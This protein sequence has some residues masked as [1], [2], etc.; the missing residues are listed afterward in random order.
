[1]AIKFVQADIPKVLNKILLSDA[2]NGPEKI[3]A[4]NLLYNLTLFNNVH[5]KLIEEKILDSIVKKLGEFIEK[6]HSDSTNNDFS[7]I[8]LIFKILINFCGNSVIIEDLLKSKI[9]EKMNSIFQKFNELSFLSHLYI[10]SLKQISSSY[11]GVM[12]L[13]NS[14]LKLIEIC[15]F[16]LES[17]NAV[18]IEDTKFIVDKVLDEEMMRQ[19]VG[20]I[21]KGEELANQLIILSCLSLENRALDSLRN[22]ALINKAISLMDND[23]VTTRHKISVIASI[24]LMVSLDETNAKHFESISGVDAILGKISTEDNLFVWYLITELMITSLGKLTVEEMQAQLNKKYFLNVIQKFEKMNPIFDSF[25][26]NALTVE[27]SINSINYNQ[28]EIAKFVLKTL[29]NIK[30]ADIVDPKL[31][32][33]FLTCKLY[34]R[35]IFW[36][37]TLLKTK[38]NVTDYEF[39]EPM[40]NNIFLMMKLFKNSKSL[41]VKIFEMFSVYPLNDVVVNFLSNNQWQQFLFDI[42][43]KKPNW[44]KFSLFVLR[45]FDSIVKNKNNIKVL[46]SNPSTVKLI[47]TIKNF[48]IEEDYREFEEEESDD[49][50]LN[51]M[52]KEQQVE[53][54][55]YSE[56]KEIQ[57]KA[58]ALIEQLI[59]SSSLVTFKGNIERGIA[60]FKPKPE[61]IQILRADYAILACINSINYFGIEG[62]KNNL[63]NVLNGYIEALEKV[64]H[65]E[66]FNEKEKLIAD[67]IRSIAN[68]ICITWSE[69]GSKQYEVSD[70]SVIVFSLFIK[71]LKNSIGPLQ[72]YVILKAF[73][74]W[75]LNR[76]EII[77]SYTGEHKNYVYFHDHF[78]LISSNKL[79]STLV[80]TLDCL[81]ENHQ[82]FNKNQKIIILNLEIINLLCQISRT[83]KLKVSGSFIPQILEI[84][85]ADNFD[86]EC[87]KKSI[88][89]L[90]MFTGTDNQTEEIN[91]QAIK[92][93]LNANGLAKIFKSISISGFDVEYINLCKPLIEGLI[94]KDSESDSSM[95]KDFVDQF[96]QKVDKFNEMTDDQKKD[97]KN[98]K[99]LSTV[100]SQLNNFCLVE[101][102][103]YYMIESKCTNKFNAVWDYTNT[104]KVADLSQA[105]VLGEIEKLSAQ[106]ILNSITSN[107]PTSNILKD[108]KENVGDYP[109]KADILTNCFK[110]LLNGYR[111]PE[112]VA[113]C[114]KI[115]NSCFPS[116]FSGECLDV[117]KKLNAAETVDTI[118]KMY[119]NDTDKELAKGT[120]EMYLNLTNS[121]KDDGSNSLVQ[122]VIKD[123]DN[124]LLHESP[125]DL[126]KNIKSL[127]PLLDKAAVLTKEDKAALEK[128]VLNSLKFLKK[129]FEDKLQKDCLQV[130]NNSLSN[131]T[132]PNLTTNERS[133]LAPEINLSQHLAFLIQNLPQSSIDSLSQDKDIIKLMEVP[134][135]LNGEMNSLKLLNDFLNNKDFLGKSKNGGMFEIATYLLLRKNKDAF[136]VASYNENEGFDKSVLFSLKNSNIQ[137]LGASVLLDKPKD[138]VNIFAST[139]M[140]EKP[141]QSR[142]FKKSKIED[143]KENFSLYTDVINKIVNPEKFNSIID[144]YLERVKAY[145]NASVPSIFSLV[146]SSRYLVS[147]L[148]I[149][150]S[151]YDFKPYA[152][153]F[154]NAFLDYFKK[155]S[156]SALPNKKL[157][158]LTEEIFARCAKKY[159][160]TKE[161]LRNTKLWNRMI[162][163]YFSLKPELVLGNPNKI[164]KNLSLAK[165]QLS[166]KN[167]I[168]VSFGKSSGKI[169]FMVDFSLINI[170]SGK[171]QN[172]LLPILANIK[173]IINKGKMTPV[174]FFN[175]LEGISR[176]QLASSEIM[177][178]DLFE[179]YITL[180]NNFEDYD[181]KKAFVEMSNIMINCL[182]N[183]DDLEF[184]K[185][186]LNQ[187]VHSDNFSKKFFDVIEKFQKS[188]FK[189]NTLALVHIFR[190]IKNPSSFYDQN[191]PEKILEVIGGGEEWKPDM[192]MYFMLFALMT[193]NDSFENM[194]SGLGYFAQIKQ[195]FQDDAINKDYKYEPLEKLGNDSVSFS[196][197]QEI[198]VQEIMIFTICDYLKYPHNTIGQKSMVNKVY[199]FELLKGFKKFTKD[200]I[201]AVKTIEAIRLI[202]QNFTEENF[203]QN[204]PELAAMKNDLNV[205]LTKHTTNK[206]VVKEIQEILNI[207]DRLQSQAAEREKQKEVKVKEDE[208]LTQ[209]AEDKPE[210]ARRMSKEDYMKLFTQK[211][212]KNEMNQFNISIT[213]LLGMLKEIN[214]RL[215]T[216]PLDDFHKNLMSIC[217][218]KING[219]FAEHSNLSVYNLYSLEVPINLR[220]I[221]NNQNAEVFYRVQCIK[222]LIDFANIED[223]LLKMLLTDFYMNK[224]IE[225]NNSILT[226]DKKL[227]SLTADEK[228]ILDNDL[229]HLKQLTRTAK[230]VGLFNDN[231]TDSG[232]LIGNMSR[233]LKSHIQLLPIKIFVIE[234]FNNLMENSKMPK[235]EEEFLNNQKLLFDE[236]Y[237]EK[238][239]VLP[240]LTSFALVAKSSKE[241]KIKLVNDGMVNHLKTFAEIYPK[242][243]FGNRN[244][245]A[246]ILELVNECPENHDPILRSSILPYLASAFNNAIGNK[247]LYE[248]VSKIILQIGY[249]NNDKKMRLIQI[250][251]SAGLITLFDIFSTG[252][253]ADPEICSSILKCMA[254]FSVMPVGAEHLLKDKIILSFQQYFNSHKESSPEQVK[255]VMITMSNMAFMPNKQNF[256]MILNDGGIQLILD[257]FVFAESQNDTD[258][259]E[260]CTDALIQMSLE[261]KALSFLELTNSLDLVMSVLR[262]QANDRLIYKG[263]MCLNQYSRKD[264]FAN[265]ILEK[266]GHS[267]AAEIVKSNPKDYKNFLQSVKLLKSLINHNKGKLTRFSQCGV[268]DKIIQSFSEDLP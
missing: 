242:N 42:V 218:D 90:K 153:K 264:S 146:V 265:K 224:C 219:H 201:L 168:K 3:Q 215:E 222:F 246:V 75:L 125:Q 170:L 145:D 51:S 120:R 92:N 197:S 239:V 184:L 28:G 256:D 251:F 88:E 1:V 108:W 198:R 58:L 91:H 165:P 203:T 20:K 252:E 49:V 45:F 48:I 143:L 109:N 21:T 63:H 259:I 174:Q 128:R 64:T 83:W 52:K 213:D 56:E 25:L 44:K 228:S 89:L 122:K 227:D 195:Y 5:K 60:N 236:N 244:L 107:N 111:N 214:K 193:E 162:K 144:E 61:I 117:Y 12:F 209:L 266:G 85:N 23:K 263:L 240:L 149:K 194:L 148:H 72:S 94:F 142:I 163:F 132:I 116:E 11:D 78:M 136:K 196:P 225:N 65:N 71:Y 59:D 243:E 22:P 150:D 248:N 39:T 206:V 95:T 154:K 235:I 35:N 79:D 97:P 10:N 37:I 208:K 230:G 84:L 205:E 123:I 24:T 46:Q 255:L 210:F 50:Q 32:L 98:L 267:I 156:K 254:N 124:S 190:R 43:L 257:C 119:E 250:G 177:K 238:T 47:A 217:I 16:A 189:Q 57:R 185:N 103:Q 171:N 245:S 36:M 134:L 169:D 192:E 113:T 223:I 186:N 31:A 216:K 234:I 253:T 87:D 226:P 141:D 204:Q 261:D 76:L 101:V 161:E 211:L 137:N 133:T 155:I 233:V 105:E 212:T 67:A 80:S 106:S 99:E 221:A 121:K 62:L 247:K 175:L 81:Y 268:P 6:P 258:L 181:N 34:G 126:I 4:F 237:H 93:M 17:C 68:F 131:I 200:Y 118:H 249:Q 262:K 180:L 69:K 140:G 182:G 15:Q 115:I 26:R 14:N 29:H 110:S 231:E 160:N 70:C 112:I 130:C 151:N 179:N 173:M 188:L 139:L 135:F 172:R 199:M 127:E 9:L 54:L 166:S 104:H 66:H 159:D 176:C 152:E 82:R 207:L 232:I 158:R 27:K 77:E 202:L 86:L 260:A 167:Y 178:N 220:L 41:Y 40:M 191:I 8:M 129:L 187:K 102:L 7:Q 157:V 241:N 73:K 2:V 13:K 18:L 183:I 55:L 38:H 229:L 114:S 96:I 147:I 100:M 19:I 164:M 74:E 138:N 30:E 53:I 33:N